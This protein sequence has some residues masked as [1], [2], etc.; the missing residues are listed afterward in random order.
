MSLTQC[1]EKCKL[2]SQLFIGINFLLMLAVTGS[3]Y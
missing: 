3:N 2:Q 1:I